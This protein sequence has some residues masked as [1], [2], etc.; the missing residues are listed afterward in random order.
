MA[1][2]RFPFIVESKRRNLSHLYAQV[3]YALLMEELAFTTGGVCVNYSNF[4]Q[5]Q[6][7][8]AEVNDF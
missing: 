8:P 4:L 7:I 2:E 3:L 5:M 6:T 1:L